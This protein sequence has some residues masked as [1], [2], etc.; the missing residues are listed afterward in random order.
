MEV[1]RSRPWWLLFVV[2]AAACSHQ[3]PSQVTTPNHEKQPPPDTG[4]LCD[5]LAGRVAGW[6]GLVPFARDAVPACF[7]ARVE[8]GQKG[9]SYGD[10]QFQRFKGD[11]SE[12]WFFDQ[13]AVVSMAD[14]LLRPT[15]MSAAQME[16]ALGPPPC[17][18]EVELAESLG[19]G[20]DDCGPD[21]KCD[22]EAVYAA[23]GIAFLLTAG[24]A[25]RV[26][27]IRVFAPVDERLYWRRFVPRREIIWPD[28]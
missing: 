16:A 24:D 23:R 5:L 17:T 7:G 10:W 2:L 27:R 15:T 11:R 13:D 3:G 1:I 6:R 22:H 9:W 26:R 21:V 4:S 20:R 12:S 25:A 28:P 14:I 18:R 8:S 19:P